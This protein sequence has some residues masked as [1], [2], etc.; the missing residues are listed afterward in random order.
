MGRQVR[1]VP[2]DWQ[3][4]K[5]SRGKFIPLL[6]GDFDAADKEW[7]E[8]HHAYTSLNLVRDYSKDGNGWK[9]KP[10]DAPFRYSDWSGRRPSPDDY[11]PKWSKGEATHFQMYEDTSEGTPISPVMDS[12]ESLAQWLADN[13][14]S[15]F[16]SM[17]ATYD[18]WLSTIRVGWAPSAVFSPATGLVSGVAGLPRKGGAT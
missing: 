12:A 18:Q 5:D 10:A 11:M 3:H 9:P 15:A 7:T 2:P 14:A 8:E 1:M 6:V 4:P 13:G 17:T 16:G